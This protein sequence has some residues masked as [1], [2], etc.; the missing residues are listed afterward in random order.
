MGMS[1]CLQ[2]PGRDE[3]GQA[4][5]L[6]AVLLVFAGVLGLGLVRVGVA[7]ARRAS[8]QA[9]ADGAALA[10]AEAGP[11]AAAAVAGA[12][13]AAV[14]GFTQEDLDVVVTVSRAGVRATARARWQPD[15]DQLEDPP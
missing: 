7:A 5:P 14:V 13:G 2:T 3:R 9:A 11:A 10:G 1:R 6:M 12:N 15:P 4:L 8:A